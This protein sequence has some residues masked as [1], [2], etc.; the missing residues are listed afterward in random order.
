MIKST[1]HISWNLV[2]SVASACPMYHPKTESARITF[3]C[4]Q[5]SSDNIPDKTNIE[6][7]FES[8]A[9]MNTT[10][11]NFLFLLIES[12]IHAINFHSEQGHSIFHKKPFKY[13]KTVIISLLSLSLL[14]F[15]SPSYFNYSVPS[16]SLHMWF[17]LP[18]QHVS[19]QPSGQDTQYTPSRF[20]TS[21]PLI[22]V[23]S[24]P[25]LNWMGITLVLVRVNND[26]LSS[27]I[28]YF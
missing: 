25:F 7:L 23:G 19:H 27:H 12:D 18:Y 14:S 22:T 13:L 10:M 1:Q 4:T 9:L 17:A 28:R 20:P 24:L 16:S 5:E 8:L 3:F 11:R 26:L 15:H 2:I 6:H 21:S